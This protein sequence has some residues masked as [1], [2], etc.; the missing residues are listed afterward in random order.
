MSSASKLPNLG[1]MIA[2]ALLV[3]FGVLLMLGD[4]D[5]RWGVQNLWP[6]LIVVLGIGILSGA[7][8]VD[9]RRSGL[10]LT[11]FGVWMLI[12]TLGLWGFH[13]GNSWPLIFFAIGLAQILQPG[14]KSRVGGL[15]ML[16]IGAIFLI[17]ERGFFDLDWN[18]AWPL[19][20]ILAGLSILFRSRGGCCRW[21]E[22]REVADERR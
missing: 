6:L 15:W 1:M 7:T 5:M 17:V 11:L 3:G 16:G 10:M 13:F 9:K 22:D 8:S 20:V 21:D 14:R 12:S 4:I 2:G 19:F 18:T